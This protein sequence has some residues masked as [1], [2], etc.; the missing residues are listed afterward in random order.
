MSKENGWPDPERP[1]F[2]QDCSCDGPHLLLNPRK[3]PVWAW[4][5]ASGSGW[6]IPEQRVLTDGPIGALHPITAGAE[7][8]YV[9]PAVAPDGKPI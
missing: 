4:W 6:Q 9:G 8:S 5:R 7:W 3:R 1:G 2:P